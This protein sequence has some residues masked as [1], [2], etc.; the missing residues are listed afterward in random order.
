MGNEGW[1]LSLGGEIRPTYERY[2]NE[3]WG[4]EPADSD[5]YLLQRYMLNADFHFGRR[6]RFF[7]QIKSGI[8][9]G[10]NGGARPPDEDKLDLHQ[11]FVDVNLW[12]R[13]RDVLTLRLGRQEFNYGSGRLI[14]TREGPNIRISFDAARLAVERAGWRVDGFVAKPVETDPGIFNDAPLHEQTLWGVYA[15]KAMR[16]LP[17]KG[18]ADLYYLGLDRKQARF[19]QGVARDLRH[20]LGARLWSRG[21]PLDYNFEMVFQ[22][23]SFGPGAIRAWTVA[24]DTGYTFRKTRW[25]PRL[26][27][28][29]NIS[30]GD[31]N[32]NN[33]DLQTFHPL[34]PRGSYF[35]QLASVGPLNH[36]DL[37][38]V[39]DL[40]FPRGVSLTVDWLLY[41]RM[42]TR[43]GIY[44]IPGNLLR[45]GQQSRARYV[46][47]QPGFELWW[48]IDRHATLFASYGRFHAGR[49]LQETPP[50]RTTRFVSLWL[51]YKF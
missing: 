10:R 21:Q 7:G 14:S 24:S 47:Y 23:G 26:G 17:G 48:E 42:S 22:F 32:P 38:P 30:S 40:R 28:R 44:G 1:F 39:L 9:T 16:W 31:K 8:E 29:A 11:A 4:A 33:P 45:T 51:T 27:L 20:S 46:G 50:S 3:N 18:N 37:H 19:D 43:D 12:E 15:V 41:W 25:Q 13:G 6:F 36:M 34:F 49:F 2:T 5:G 35:A